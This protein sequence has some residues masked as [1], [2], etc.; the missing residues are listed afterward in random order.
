[1]VLTLCVFQLLKNIKDKFLVLPE[2]LHFSPRI[3]GDSDASD[4]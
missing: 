2:N 3:S 4:S 1:M